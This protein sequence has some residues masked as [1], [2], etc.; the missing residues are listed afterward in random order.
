MYHPTLSFPVTR[1]IW[2]SPDAILL[3]FAGGA[4]EFAAI[5]AVDWLFFTGRLPGA[6]VERFFETVSFAQSV[7]F[8]D[9]A[10]AI[11]AIER[12][13]RIHR[14]VEQAR[15]EEIPQWAY[16]DMLFILIDYGERAHEVVFGPMTESERA[17]HFGVGLALGRAMHLSGLPTTYAEYR[18]QR[19]QQLLE[20]YA[21]GPLTDELYASYRRALGPLRF[22]LLELVQASVLPEELRDTL[23]LKPYPLVGELLRYYRFVPGGG[24]KLRPLHKVLLPGRFARQLR[25][26]ELARDVR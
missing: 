22:R 11:E 7:F 5:K 13:N 1:R 2:G 8:G 21:R 26:M 16:R 19:H 25:E 23:R 9:A 14:G 17:S 3:F 20:D 12:I 24:N 18:N 6:P 4:A 15:G 10:G